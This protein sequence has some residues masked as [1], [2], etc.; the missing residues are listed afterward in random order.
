MGIKTRA[1]SRRND[2]W[3]VG[4]KWCKLYSDI[5]IGAGPKN[6]A[7]KLARPDKKG[8]STKCVVKGINLNYKNTLD[9]NYDTLKDI[10]TGE[11]KE[12]N[13]QR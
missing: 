4:H 6:H 1:L 3:I 7:F 11:K 9:I 10:V 2:G 12:Y 13:M 5:C 8:Y